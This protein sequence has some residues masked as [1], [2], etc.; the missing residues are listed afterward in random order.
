[1]NCWGANY[2]GELGNGSQG[3]GIT[4]V[5]VVGV[6][7]IGFLSGVASLTN[8]FGGTTCALLIS[9]GVD[10]W[11]YGADGMFGNG[12]T[13]SSFA[14]PV[15]VV[16]VGGSGTLGGVVSLA[17]NGSGV[18]TE[19]GRGGFCALLISGGVDCWGYGADGELGNGTATTSATPVQVVDVGGSG[20]LGGVA[21]LPG[22][23][24][25]AF[26]AALT[27]GGVDC[28]GGGGLL[29]NGSIIGSVV[30]VQVAAVS[31]V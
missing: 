20:T 25:G 26:C 29:G 15:Q 21:S 30:P 10:C 2:D 7:K 23:V 24:S 13:A 12:G 31:G 14:T 4:P 9:G 1:M 5:Q 3:S 6:G 11:G 22:N 27:S 18:G 28:W 19:A 8:S 16:D 17:G